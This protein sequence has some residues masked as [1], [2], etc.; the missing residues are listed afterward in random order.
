ME[1]MLFVQ[2]NKYHLIQWCT[3]SQTSLKDSDYPYLKDVKNKFIMYV[4]RLYCLNVEN[5]I[6]NVTLIINN[7]KKKKQQQL[8]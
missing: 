5:V 4:L 8:F 1:A 6:K 2:C 7:E 3:W